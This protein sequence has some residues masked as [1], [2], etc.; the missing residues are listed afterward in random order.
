M[1]IG[2]TSA[3]VRETEPIDGEAELAGPRVAPVSSPERISSVDVLR[4]VALLGILLMNIL[5]FGMAWRGGYT[6]DLAP[7]TGGTRADLAF[8]AASHVLF[9]GKMRALFSML[10]GAGVVLLTSRAEERGGGIRV[11]D[12][13]YRR[14]LWLIV[15]GLVHAYFIWAGDILFFYGVTGLMLFPFRNSRPIGLIA[16]GLF[17]L[18]IIMLKGYWGAAELRQQRDKAASADNVAATGKAL[19][20]EQRDAQREWADVLK[21]FKPSSEAIAKSISEHRGSYSTLFTRRAQWV[22]HAESV[23]LYREYFFDVGGM[24]LIGMGLM[25]LGVFSG[26]GST[27]FYLGMM[28][29]GYGFGA[30]LNAWSGY[31]IWSHDFDHFAAADMNLWYSPG[32]LA[33]ALGHVGLILTLYRAGLFSG[34]FERLSAV[35]RMALT[36]YLGTSVVCTLIFNGYG[37]G[38]YDRLGRAQLLPV[39]LAV[40]GIQLLLSPLWLRRFRYGPAEWLWRSLTYWRIQ[41]LRFE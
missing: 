35:G 33:V 16:A 25:K 31:R 30:S 6:G 21:G 10:F 14:T 17:L 12:I 32:R 1:A 18:S 23:E 34:L 39:V 9:E 2:E 8:W 26:K 11:A 3:E 20:K 36:N 22:S 41:P 13:Y 27:R 15:F 40:W 5:D 38:F 19:N 4:G 28:L 24:M 37:L 29:L 7:G